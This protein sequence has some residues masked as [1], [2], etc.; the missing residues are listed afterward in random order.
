MQD[1][2]II[3]KHERIRYVYYFYFYF[4]LKNNMCNFIS[5][6]VV[7][8]CGE[9]DDPDYGQVKFISTTVGSEAIYS[10]N[11]GFILVGK[12]IRECLINGVWS[13]QAPTCKSEC[14]M[15]IT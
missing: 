9:L 6:Y 10:C 14:H 12:D 7:I 8:D 4:I 15:N 2:F 13:G 1:I 5:F 11:R 3:C